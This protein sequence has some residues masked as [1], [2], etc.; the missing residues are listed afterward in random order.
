MEYFNSTRKNSL[1]SYSASC[2]VIAGLVGLEK[3]EH[4]PSYFL[5]VSVTSIV[6]N[7]V[8]AVIAMFGNALVIISIWRTPSLH[9]PS[10]VLICSLSVS[11]FLVGFVSQPCFVIRNTAQILGY[12]DTY[13]KTFVFHIISSALFATAS[14]V[15]LTVMSVD[16]YLALRLHMRYNSVV[17]ERKIV[18][19]VLGCW[20]LVI[21]F[22]IA[23]W[24]SIRSRETMIAFPILNLPWILICCWC[25]WKIF[26]IIRRHR[27]QIRHDQVH[28]ICGTNSANH[29][30]DMARYRRTSLHCRSSVTLL[31]TTCVLAD[32]KTRYWRRQLSYIGCNSNFNIIRVLKLLSE[33][34]D[35][36]LESYRIATGRAPIPKGH[37]RTCSEMFFVEKKV[38]L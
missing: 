10:N 2:G 4:F 31:F 36:F 7:A 8:C 38:H 20:I 21:P 37:Q 25:Y 5:I 17:T 11:D 33:S 27:R 23:P 29:H 12:F 3:R 34:T 28:V 26:Q 16:R 18:A 6:I 1:E 15:T 9:S 14:L 13:C 22:S 30:P 35:L 24:L 19:V 32:D